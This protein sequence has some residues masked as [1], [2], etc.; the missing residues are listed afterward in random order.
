MIVSGLRWATNWKGVAEELLREN[1]L[2]P[3]ALAVRWRLDAVS[4]RWFG[5]MAIGVGLDQFG[6]ALRH[7]SVRGGGAV[8]LVGDG[9]I[10]LSIGILVRRTIRARRTPYGARSPSG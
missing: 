9:L 5:V 10:V 4:W 1:P 2:I 7:L 6:S 8:Q 3:R